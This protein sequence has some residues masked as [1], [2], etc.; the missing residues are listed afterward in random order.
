MPYD[1][2][3]FFFVFTRHFV[4]AFSLFGAHSSS[5]TFF[6]QI[7][8]AHSKLHH[9]HFKMKSETVKKFEKKFTTFFCFN[10]SSFFMKNTDVVSGFG[11]SSLSYS[12]TY[13]FPSEIPK[14]IKKIFALWQNQAIWFYCRIFYSRDIFFNGFVIC[15]FDFFSR[16]QCGSC[17]CG[18]VGVCEH[19]RKSSKMHAYMYWVI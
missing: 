17:E 16:A 8:Q 13:R 18:W 12:L 19:S 14:I 9:K 10:S 11:I 4:N 3:H 2:F 6:P 15:H 1:G 5:I 7:A